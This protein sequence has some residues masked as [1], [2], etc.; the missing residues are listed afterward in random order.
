MKQV[1]YTLQN[2]CHKMAQGKIMY[3]CRT[4]PQKHDWP[5]T[6]ERAE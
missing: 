4:D 3:K 6:T 1:N 2:I 5:V